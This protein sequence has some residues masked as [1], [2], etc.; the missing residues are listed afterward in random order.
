MSAQ[1]DL[2]H[3]FNGIPF[4]TKSSTAL[5]RSLNNF[6]ARE[7]DLLL[8]SYPKSGTHWLAE[9]LRQLYSSKAPHK[10]SITSPIEFGEVSTL[11]EMKSINAK[12]IIPTHLGYDMIPTD[13][14]DRKCKAIYIIRNPK[15][16]AV[17]LF[18]YYKD[19]PNLPT[20]DSWHVFFDIFLHGQAVCGSWF[21]HLLGWE[22]HRNE[23]SIFIL[24]Y[25]A[26]KKDL[27]K[28][29]RK[30]SSFLGINVN[31]NEISEICKKTSFTE[32]KT[33][34][35]KE[36]SDPNNTVCALTTNKRLIFR[37]GT[38]GE[39]KN[40]FSPKQNRQFDDLCKTMLES[41]YLAK[42]ILYEN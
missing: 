14:K 25:E 29:V 27:P 28:S 4:S 16:T 35:E 17:S 7:D 32:M 23:M 34:V 15:D 26:M 36:N 3:M 20:I 24:Y 2:L 22:Q 41:S 11:E 30:I 42:N 1:S 21:D 8:V 37:K 10:V 5:L 38:V 9:I 13:F 39:W 40:Y 6:Q 33:N 31:D 19:N 12:R 18:H